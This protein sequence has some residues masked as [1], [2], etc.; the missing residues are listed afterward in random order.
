MVQSNPK[1]RLP[2]SDELPCSDE[3]PVDNENQN[4]IPNFLLFLLEL[5]WGNRQNWF[6]GVDMG[7]YHNTGDNP[8]IPVVPD[9]FLSVGVE[10]RKGGSSRSSYVLWEENEVVPILF[11]EVVSWTYGGEYE[12]KMQTYARLGVLYYIVYNPDYWKRDRHQ[13]LEVYR[14]VDGQYQLQAGEPLWMPEL[15]LGI[16]RC[17]LR[18]GGIDREVLC[19]YDELGSRYLTAEE[20][21]FDAEERAIDAEETIKRVMAELDRYRQ[22]FGELPNGNSH[23]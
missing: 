8:R 19:W 3:T 10:R 15:E 2:S 18:V 22:Q 14:L 9:G 5:I 12:D 1:L 20:R 17:K 7:I 13:P 4:F 23:E 16:G 21:A 6:L 11:L